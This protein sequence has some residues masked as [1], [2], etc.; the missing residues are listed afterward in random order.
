M[1]TAASAPD[2]P[3]AA[4]ADEAPNRWAVL[5]LVA[6][7]EL[8]GM[9]LWFTASAAA[10]ELAQRWGLGSSQTAFLTTAVQLGF[11]C[12]TALSAFLN[13]ADLAPSRWL[14]AASATCAA[15]ANYGVLAVDRY[16][17]AV[18][19]RFATGLCLAGVYPPA[20]KMIATWFRRRRGLAIGVVV[21]ALTA[22]K[23]LPYLLR[24]APGSS[25]PPDAAAVIAWASAGALA[26][27]GLIAAFY[28][29][30][31][32]AF[33]RRRFSWALAGGVLA[34]R[35]TRLAITGY[36]GH[37]W[38]LYAMWTWIPAFVAASLAAR[39]EPAGD[40]RADG[41][42][43]AAI[44]VGALGCVWGGWAADR[45][46]RE[47]VVQLA[48]TVSGLCAAA[49][50]LVFGLPVGGVAT[51]AIVWGF[52]VVADS[53]QFSALVTERAPPH[54]VG[55]ALTLQTSLGFLLTV[56]T[57]QCV[58]WLADQLG[59]RWAPAVLALGPLAGYEAMRRLR[60]G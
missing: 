18:G 38:E 55:T 52:F 14:F 49:S 34:D 23:A 57:I 25:T 19:L 21:G 13:L 46:G 9:S 17:A 4:P 39:G 32:H 24:A 54:A 11:V 33:P 2:N 48:L 41:I 44:A 53:A 56:V 8:L 3:P 16:D 47:R 26:A 27:A 15:A 12:G 58:P 5:A 6:G 22:G 30:G 7:A 59:W 1:S 50:G 20:M 28:R 36:L 37:M 35:P 51:L 40:G 60:A 31:P 42:A 43:F 29:D 45:A 10:P